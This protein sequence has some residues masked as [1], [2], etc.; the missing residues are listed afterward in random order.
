MKVKLREING[1]N[2]FQRVL[3]F[4]QNKNNIAE[5][6]KVQDTLSFLDAV[7]EIRA[8]DEW[9]MQNLINMAYRFPH[10]RPVII[11]IDKN[12]CLV[13]ASY[14]FLSR[15]LYTLKGKND[16]ESKKF[17]NFITTLPFNKYITAGA[18]YVIL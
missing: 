7:F 4:F 8:S 17:R 2:S 16:E 14:Y 5:E 9:I 13:K 3:K 6:V 10:Y 12:T 1:K 18:R 11:I 15:M